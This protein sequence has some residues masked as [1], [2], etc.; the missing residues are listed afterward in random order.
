MIN[1][2]DEHNNG[3]ELNREE[4]ENLLSRIGFFDDNSNRALFNN[5]DI[6]VFDEMMANEIAVI[7]QPS[8]GETVFFDFRV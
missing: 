4:A 2:F 5:G 1:N 7:L 6:K 3:R 8:T